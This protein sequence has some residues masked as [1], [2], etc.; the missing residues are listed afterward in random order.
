MQLVP[1]SRLKPA[2]WNPRVISD[3]R[4]QKLCQSIQRDPEFLK[5]RP[6]LA[7]Q[8]G[9]VYAGNQRFRAAEHLGLTEIPAILSDIPDTLA[10]ERALLDNNEFGDWADDGLKTILLEL[11]QAGTDLHGLG[12]S[13]AELSK[14]LDG[15]ATDLTGDSLKLS[16][17]FEVIVTCGTADE[18]Q[19]A[20][21]F[22]TEHGYQCR[23]VQA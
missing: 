16:S 20:V 18:Q 13:D 22:L 21:A 19:Q 1:L 3:E 23:A 11:S 8:D 17:T 5:L 12:F 15:V 9:T 14:L 10:K 2:A 7:I 4:F 6:V